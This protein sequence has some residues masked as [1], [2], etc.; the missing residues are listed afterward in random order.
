MVSVRRWQK[1][2]ASKLNAPCPLQM[3][4]GRRERATREVSTTTRTPRAKFTMQ[5][6]GDDLPC[7]G[8]KMNGIATD[9]TH[10][11]SPKR[12]D[13]KPDSKPSLERFSTLLHVPGRSTKE[14][15][16]V[17]HLGGVRLTALAVHRYPVS[18][19]E[20]G[21]ETDPELTNQRHVCVSLTVHG[22]SAGR[23]QGGI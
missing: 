17:P 19:Q 1:L 4:H 8:E 11:Q 13:R 22:A 23:Q 5:R 18:H 21:V 6:V 15:V 20:A 12:K 3:K 16:I 7:E 10:V 14:D 2:K 9:I